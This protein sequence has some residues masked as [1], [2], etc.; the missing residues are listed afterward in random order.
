MKPGERVLVVGAGAIGLAVAFWAR[1]LGAAE[2]IVADLHSLQEQRALSLGATR[3]LLS[4]DELAARLEQSCPG[5]PDIVFECVGKPGL[6]DFCI[7]LVRPRGKVVVLGLCTAPDHMDSFRAISKEV[8]IVMSVFFDMH[9]FQR[10]IDA[11]EADRFPPQG[12]ISDTIGLD[13]V[14]IT[15]E[16]LRRRTTQCK[17]LIDPFA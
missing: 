17:V 14:P 11:L 10:A 8:D 9:E 13:A 1:R 4:G 3:F 7:S 5:G 16:A 2:V 15:F 12:L 6:I